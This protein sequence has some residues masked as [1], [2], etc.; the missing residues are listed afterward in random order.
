ML[1]LSKKVEYAVLALQYIAANEGKIVPAKEIAENL[2]ISF[3]FLS[4]TLQTLMKRKLI[5]SQHGTKGGYV[6]VKKPTEMTKPM[7]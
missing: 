7:S 2:H 1:R 5:S 6:L 4:K 3:E